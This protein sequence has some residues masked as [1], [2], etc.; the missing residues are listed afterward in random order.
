MRSPLRTG[1][2]PNRRRPDHLRSFPVP[3]TSPVLASQPCPA[4]ELLLELAEE[5]VQTLDRV[6][7]QGQEKSVEREMIEDD[8]AAAYLALGRSSEAIALQQSLL[9]YNLKTRG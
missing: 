4:S 2:A 7:T 6:E 9:T 8:L 1:Q 5:V 3:Q